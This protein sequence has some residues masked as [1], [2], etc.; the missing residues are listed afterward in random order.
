MSLRLVN[1][2]PTSWNDSLFQIVSTLFNSP[3]PTISLP[4][5]TTKV[6]GLTS[7]FSEKMETFSQALLQSA[8]TNLETTFIRA[9]TLSPPSV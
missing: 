4:I 3:A 6:F 2:S 7:Y 5:S 9:G 8:A 1:L